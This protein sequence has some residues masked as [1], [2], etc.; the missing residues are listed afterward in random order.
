MKKLLVIFIAVCCALCLSG[1]GLVGTR[2][3]DLPYTTDRAAE[4]DTSYSALNIS[5]VAETYNND[6]GGQSALYTIGVSFLGGVL[7]E[8]D[9]IFAMDNVAKDLRI[10]L[11][12]VAYEAISES[13]NLSNGYYDYYTFLV[14]REYESPLSYLKSDYGFFYARHK[15]SLSAPQWISDVKEA[16]YRRIKSG[17]NGANAQSNSKIEIDP[18]CVRLRYYFL[19]DMLEADGATA[20]KYNN[21]RNS[22]MWET[23]DDEYFFEVLILKQKDMMEGWDIVPII[24]GVVVVL[25]LFA[26]C[27]VAKKLKKRDDVSEI[28]GTSGNPFDYEHSNDGAK[29]DPFDSEKGSVPQ[30]NH[31]ENESAKVENQI[32]MDELTSP[33]MEEP[34]GKK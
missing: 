3:S 21:T 26:W 4:G 18:D 34:D 14:R 23:T 17:F 11:E 1:C 27:F 16:V 8:D 25:A 24:L 2:E 28:F 9:V 33:V 10:L 32:L 29:I 31:Y 30:D 5:V 22:I 19:G 12:P 20:V 6:G 7:D 13:L 15:Y